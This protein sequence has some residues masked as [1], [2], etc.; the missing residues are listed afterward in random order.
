VDGM[1]HLVTEAEY[2]REMGYVFS[3]GLVKLVWS[4]EGVL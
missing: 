4:L 3:G 2:R 1:G